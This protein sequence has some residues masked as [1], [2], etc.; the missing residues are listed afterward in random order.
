MLQD[1]YEQHTI[2]MN[3]ELERTQFIDLKEVK[4]NF[5]LMPQAALNQEKGNPS[6]GDPNFSY[7]NTTLSQCVMSR[8]HNNE[9]RQA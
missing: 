4:R 3:K 9:A 1:T 7:N 8:P 2:G 6:I 5:N